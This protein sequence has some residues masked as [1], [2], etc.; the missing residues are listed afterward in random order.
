MA[1]VG[2]TAFTLSD[3]RKR[4]GAD[5]KIDYIIEVLE[6]SNPIMEHIVW[7]EGNL[8]TGNLT[9]LRTNYPHPE[10]RRINRGVGNQKSNTRQ[11][12]DTCCI[13]EARCEVDVRLLQMA[14]DAQALRR[15]EDAAFI[16]GFAQTLAKYMF[17]GDTER[18]PDE[19]N[20]LGIRFNTFGGEK[21]TFGYQT[22]NAGGSTANKQTSAYLVDWGER[23]VAGIYPKGSKAGLDHKDLGETDAIDPDGRK[24]RAVSSLF[25]WD[26]GLAVMDVRKAAAIRNIDM[27]TAVADWTAASR[28]KVIDN[29]ILA[30]NR[31]KNPKAPKLYVS[32][33]LYNTI[34]LFL[35]DKTNVYVTRQEL[36]GQMPKLYVSGMEVCKCDALMETEPVIS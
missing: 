7:Q 28:R 1:T 23:A 11:V 22:I 14:A 15:S 12:T 17:Y 5:G 19:F 10:L 31:I 13:M 35:T 4:L 18:H 8:P 20:G 9:T 30:K 32:D 26:A 6:Q 29:I 25:T 33:N 3:L 27:N 36:M 24:Y 2:N 34:E 21:G 16:E